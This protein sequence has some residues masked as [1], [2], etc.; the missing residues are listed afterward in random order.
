[1]VTEMS[2]PQ[3]EKECA[4]IS[5]THSGMTTAKGRCNA[6]L[7]NPAAANAAW[8]SAITTGRSLLDG[9]SATAASL[10]AIR[11]QLVNCARERVR[12]EYETKTVTGR[13][14]PIFRPI[15]HNTPERDHS[16]LQT[17]R[18]CCNAL[19]RRTAL[20][21]QRCERAVFQSV[22]ASA[23][24]HLDMSARAS[25]SAT[26]PTV[27]TRAGGEWVALERGPQCP[28]V[29]ILSHN[30]LADCY[31]QTAQRQEKAYL[32]NPD[33]TKLYD[34]VPPPDLEWPTRRARL[35][36]EFASLGP[37]LI[38]LQEVEFTTFEHELAPELQRL[39]YE[40]VIQNDPKRAERQSTG[41]ATFHRV[42][43]LQL[44]WQEHR[45]RSLATEYSPAPRGPFASA[46]P[47]RLAVGNVHL[48]G[49]PERGD[50]RL[51]QFKSVSKTMD[52]R[53]RAAA[54]L[55]DGTRFG[56]AVVGDYNEDVF[57]KASEIG[58]LLSGSVPRAGPAST[59]GTPTFVLPG[60]Q[61]EIDFLVSVADEVQV[62][63]VGD[64]TSDAVEWSE[65][66]SGGLPNAVIA[67]DHMP[68]ATNLSAVGVAVA[69]SAAAPKDMTVDELWETCPLS[70]E[71]RAAL[72]QLLQEERLA[73]PK[74][75]PSPEQ[76]QQLA[77][78]RKR[79]EALEAGM[80]D[81][82]VAFCSKIRK[83]VRKGKKSK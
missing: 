10:A 9:P 78:L 3:L 66:L 58:K 67:S 19:W 38:C 68:T 47:F 55:G 21:L 39:G 27:S 53:R 75:K 41:N 29:W 4:E 30:I 18:S 52:K 82:S 31:V 33:G 45:S 59:H 1:M 46:T 56:A 15:S 2:P 11:E 40:G 64:F 79:K 60:R 37:D 76:L 26:V 62:H 43:A 12:P 32:Q 72:E 42:A 17:V 20:V 70:P 51:A 83:A 73:Q 44:V 50:L 34:H 80:G 63:A 57:D 23:Q 6:S 5:V 77:G 69:E 22:K 25:E 7:S 16:I 71:Q 49:D 13:L 81:D 36:A 14:T 65:V 74:G 35:L 28:G 54:G 24:G 61:F 8:S 48:Q